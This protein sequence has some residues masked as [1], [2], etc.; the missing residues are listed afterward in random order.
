M[1]VR[2]NTVRVTVHSLG[3]V[4][5]PASSVTILDESGKVISTA[6]V[7]ALKAPLDYLPKTTNVTLNIPAGTTIKGCMVKLNMDEKFS[8]ITRLNNTVVIR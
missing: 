2:G 6:D 5:A 7:P 8:E 4:D 1:I 3:A